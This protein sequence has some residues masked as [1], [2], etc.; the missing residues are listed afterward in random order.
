MLPAIAALMPVTVLLLCADPGAAAVTVV[1]SFETPSDLNNWSV[2]DGTAALSDQHATEGRMSLHITWPTGR[3]VLLNRGALPADWSKYEFL[4]VDVYN[5]GAPV[6]VTLRTDDADG[7]TIS[8]WYHY[9][10]T[11]KSTV[12]FPLR[13]LR[14]R[15]DISRI[16]MAHLRI[17]PPVEHEVEL[18]LDNLRFTV[19]EP[20]EVYQPEAKAEVRPIPVRPNM[21]PNPDFELGL[22]GWGS[23]GN[24][25]GGSYTFG[26]A[27]GENAYSGRYSAAIF[28]NRKGRG[29][30]MT[31]PILMPV[32]GKYAL[33]FWAKASEASEIMY[34]LEGSGFSRYRRTPV[35]TEWQRI[36]MQVPVDA[37]KRLRVYLMSVGAG[38]V[39]LDEV[40]LVGDQMPAPVAATAAG[41][42]PRKVECR[43]DVLLV[44]GKPFFAIGI[45]RAAPNDLAG[46]AFNC[47]PGW[48]SSDQATLDA[49]AQAG[50]YM[51]PDL[52]GLMR[53]HL[54]QQAALCI[55]DLM[56][57]PAVLAW[58]VCDEPDHAAWT[59]PP[60][61]MELARKVLRAA[62]PYHPTCAVVMP[63]AESNLYGYADCVDILMAD[64]YPI[65]TKKPTNF[66]SV[67]RANDIMRRATKFS[68]PTWSV[69]Q[70]T[71]QATPEEETAVVYLSITHGA[72]GVLF[73]EYAD[74]HKN[75]AVWK[76]IVTLAEEMRQLTPAL[77]S[78]DTSQPATADN[79]AI[80]VLAKQA[81]DGITVI[82][83]NGSDAPATGVQITV[84]GLGTKI[85]KRLLEAT[86]GLAIKATNGTLSD[87]F[88][89]YERHV[90]QF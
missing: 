66:S 6:H 74:A 70:G 37:G 81:P 12:E 61:E 17:D 54:P 73:W 25:D 62:D 69:I 38:T 53:G 41:L 56:N 65:G 78:P 64:P 87:D 51:L 35:G 31:A 49:C 3:G 67:T 72:R 4:K 52:S 90:Y 26:T 19:G 59:V 76:Q 44:D 86:A 43:G 88:A 63:W 9:L 32:T 82:A 16:T 50:I 55:R 48:D 68:K 2:S 47:I 13:A 20:R 7:A 14:E 28:C 8:S 11:G 34:G 79:D 57:H 42:K 10:R 80:S 27:D 29:G 36:E 33:T 39:Y 83:V 22:Q 85:G 46:T 15:I 60:D 45:Y 30:I 23:W 24:W 71:A 5:P 40:T 58:Y 84:P 89:P 21:I 1:S 77:T 75:P 18:Y